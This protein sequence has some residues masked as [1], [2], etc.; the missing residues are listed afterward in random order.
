MT[1]LISFFFSISVKNKIGFYKLSFCVF[2]FNSIHC[3]PTPILRILTQI[4]CIPTPILLIPT[5][6]L[7]NPTAFPTFQP[8]FP[9]FPSQFRHSAPDSPFQLLQIAEMF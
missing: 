5:Q 4:S 3:I 6:I 7:R 9:E 2:Y 8:R 1:I